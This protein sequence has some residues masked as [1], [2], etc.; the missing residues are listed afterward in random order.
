MSRVTVSLVVSS[1]SSETQCCAGSSLT[2]RVHI[3]GFLAGNWVRPDD[4]VLIDYWLAPLD[5]S[6]RGGGIDLLDARV[7]GLQAVQ[8]LLEQ[9][10]EP[11]VRLDGVHKER[12]SAGL[13]LIEDI[14]EGRSGRLLLVRHVRVPR[15][16]AC[17]LLEELLSTRVS[18]PAVYEV[19]FRE[20]FGRPGSWVDVVPPEVA[21]IVES[22]L[23]G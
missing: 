13:G 5:A 15:D 16:G 14:Q 12:I 2:L 20:S 10:A 3:D 22:L 9:R 6:P 23:D 21:A 8:S 19:D 1:N 7:R 11:V 4:G 18:G 17:P